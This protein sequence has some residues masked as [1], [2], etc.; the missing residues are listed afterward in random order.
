MS[1]FSNSS[2]HSRAT[3]ATRVPQA[4]RGEEPL[5]HP[6]SHLHCWESLKLCCSHL[7]ATSQTS[8]FLQTL[9]N[10]P[11]S[12]HLTQIYWNYSAQQKALWELFQLITG[13]RVF[14]LKCPAW[15]KGEELFQ[16]SSAGPGEGVNIE[17]NPNLIL[18]MVW[19][20]LVEGTL[21]AGVKLAVIYPD[22]GRNYRQKLKNRTAVVPGEQNCSHWPV[23]QKITKSILH[24]H[25]WQHSWPITGNW[26]GLQNH[27]VVQNNTVFWATLKQKIKLQHYLRQV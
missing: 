2:A 7:L 26:T 5:S 11:T 21:V 27:K 19:K 13:L 18:N 15:S 10:H 3:S 17:Q 4:V 23:L 8:T 6:E 9:R 1:P 16:G 25:Y 24:L 14:A 12:Q 20:Y 22:F